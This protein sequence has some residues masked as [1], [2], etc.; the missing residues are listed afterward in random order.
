MIAE[1]TEV[2]KVKNIN[3]GQYSVKTLLLDMLTNGTYRNLRSIYSER[4]VKRTIY[5]CGECF[6]QDSVERKCFLNS[7]SVCKVC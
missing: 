4:H 6:F 3:I 2:Y 7:I 5:D 1:I